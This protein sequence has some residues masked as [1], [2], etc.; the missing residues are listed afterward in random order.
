MTQ[1]QDEKSGLKKY[2]IT[3]S[4][5]IEGHTGG[6]TLSKSA[7]VW[8]SSEAQLKH[9]VDALTVKCTESK[10]EVEL[11]IGDT[12]TA[13]VYEGVKVMLD[14][15]A[16]KYSKA[17]P[18]GGAPWRWRNLSIIRG[19]VNAFSIRVLVSEDTNLIEQGLGK[20]YVNVHSIGCSESDAQDGDPDGEGV[21]VW[22]DSEGFHEWVCC[23][24][25]DLKPLLN[26]LEQLISRNVTLQYVYTWFDDAEY[27]FN[28]TTGKDGI[29]EEATD[30]EL[31]ALIAAG[32][33]HREIVIIEL[34]GDSYTDHR[35]LCEDG[36]K[37]AGMA[38]SV[39]I[40]DWDDVR[41]TEAAK[42]E[43]AKI[44]AP[45]E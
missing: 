3:W 41:L 5:P 22:P 37:F 8:A 42:D 27:F 9:L 36:Y 30:A 33:G 20:R 40:L 43:A 32:M 7:V 38:Q 10:P 12:L 2:R 34:G 16:K 29:L 19:G 35:D 26:P 11:M 44:D 31:E 25:L 6:M 17:S 21:Q 14:D 24:E 13:L 1:E 15:L 45:K 23:L 39:I 28:Q 4:E 18:K